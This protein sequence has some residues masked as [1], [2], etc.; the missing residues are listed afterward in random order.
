MSSAGVVIDTLRVKMAKQMAVQLYT[1][2]LNMPYCDVKIDSGMANNAVPVQSVFKA[3][4]PAWRNTTLYILLTSRP[5]LYHCLPF[6]CIV[7]RMLIG[8]YISDIISLQ[9]TYSAFSQ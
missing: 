7:C 5:V 8:R 9:F 4:L 1:L 2:K 3:E 6:L